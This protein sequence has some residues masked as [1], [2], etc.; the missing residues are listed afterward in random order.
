VKTDQNGRRLTG[1]ARASS[2][3]W[4]QSSLR[5]RGRTVSPDRLSRRIAI[6]DRTAMSLL[7]QLDVP[8][9]LP[10]PPE[11]ASAQTRAGQHGSA[12]G[13]ERLSAL[14]VPED[15]QHVKAGTKSEPFQGDP[16][17]ECSGP[18]HTCADHRQRYDETT[19]PFDP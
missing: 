10:A 7:P 17:R 5:H 4:H 6:F 19:L 18:T 13:A 3:L 16:E 2:L 1:R 14:R 12:A 11:P 15:L 8:I 9:H